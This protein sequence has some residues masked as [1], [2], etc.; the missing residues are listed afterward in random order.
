MA[1]AELAKGHEGRRSRITRDDQ[2][3]SHEPI[4]G[5]IPRQPERF[6]GHAFERLRE[7]FAS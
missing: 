5:A 3:E 6:T 1:K 4:A 7:S 2:R